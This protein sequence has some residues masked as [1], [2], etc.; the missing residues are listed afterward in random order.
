MLR[1]V[2]GYPGGGWK[3]DWVAWVLLTVPWM[4][5]LIEFIPRWDINT[6]LGVARG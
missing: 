2:K 1:L 5:T 4:A 6:R 3:Q